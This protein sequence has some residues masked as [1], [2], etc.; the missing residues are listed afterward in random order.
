MVDHLEQLVSEATL[1]R[2]ADLGFGWDPVDRQ[3]VAAVRFGRTATDAPVVIGL[4][5][6]ASSGKSTLFNSLMGRE[7]SRVSAHAHETVGA[8][9]SVH[10]SKNQ[11]VTDWVQ[12]GAM[13][14]GLEPFSING[15]SAV[16][17][18]V[19]SVHF[20][21]HE[22]DDW[23]EVVLVDLP[24]VTSR[25]SVDEG[26]VTRRLM[27]WFDGLI[28][29]VDEERWF[30]VTVFDEAV[31]LARSME[32]TTW[33]V[34]NCT[35]PG[36][37]V[38]REVRER[39][40]EHATGRE[41]A[42]HCVSGY[43]AGSG[44]RAMSGDV[45]SRVTGWV[46]SCKAGSRADALERRLRQRCSVVWRQNVERADAYQTLR[47]EIEASSVEAVTDAR[48]SLDLLTGDEKSLLGVGHRFLP[49]YDVVQG[50][51]RQWSKWT[52]R[53]TASSEIEFDKD[54]D[55]IGDV[56][57]RNLEHRFGEATG[58]VDRIV[59]GSAYLAET[60]WRADWTT[61]TFDERAWA[62]R[63]RSHIDAWK[64]ETGKT[65]RRGDAAAV[66]LGMPLLVADLLFLGGA[67]MTWTWASAWV[68]G[69]LGGKALTSVFQ[70]SPAFREYQTTVTA[71]QNLIRE[72]LA[73]QCETNFARMPRRH[74]LMN[75]PLA[76]SLMAWSGPEVS[77]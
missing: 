35:E 6:G 7:I 70:K 41:A 43:S 30:D 44:F 24:D 56:L 31:A 46:R 47:R 1:T 58:R 17:G 18:E 49:L 61:P 15:Q 34:F 63:V 54:V 13:M 38:T 62:V 76:Q 14:P 40:K 77:R 20:Y 74:L 75:D 64:K 28:V 68:A 2:L 32:P 71:Y 16:G 39:L 65:S 60:D 52:G 42:D 57:R 4:I 25:M 12:G 26:A 23:S 11:Q 27:P 37:S 55:R 22:T 69:F 67:G 29:V 19:G 66:A 36:L 53:G 21:A 10:A 8:V 50:I 9:A 3:T 45:L 5:G 51:G 33:I 59:A 73:E 72:S 48:L